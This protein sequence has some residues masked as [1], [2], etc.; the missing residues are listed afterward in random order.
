MIPWLGV[1]LCLI[2]AGAELSEA[3][4]SFSVLVFVSSLD[5]GLQVFLLRG[6]LCL[7]A[8]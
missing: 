8:F 1:G 2:L 4:I 7:V 6:S 3:K 5:F